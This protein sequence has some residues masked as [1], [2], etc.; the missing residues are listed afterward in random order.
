MTHNNIVKSRETERSTKSRC[1]A[2]LQHDCLDMEIIVAHRVTEAYVVTTATNVDTVCRWC[3]DP[4]IRWSDHLQKTVWTRHLSD[5][6]WETNR[7][8]LLSEHSFGFCSV[9]SL[10]FGLLVF[11]EFIPCA[12]GSP[13]LPACLS[14]C[15]PCFS[16]AQ[17]LPSFPHLHHPQCLN[18]LSF[19]I[20][21]CVCVCVWVH[22]V[23]LWQ[24][25]SAPK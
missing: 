13:H 9:A 18:K 24:T 14:A 15:N 1:T 5:L 6:I 19:C 20:I 10:M 25:V 23:T 7:I 3:L 11:N 4:K 8:C 2:T 22:L 12:S 17:T 16:T 21:P